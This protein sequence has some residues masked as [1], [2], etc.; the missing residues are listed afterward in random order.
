MTEPGPRPTIPYK[1]LYV[2]A[3]GISHFA[4]AALTEFEFKS[5]TS[6]QQW[7]G[8]KHQGSMTVQFAVLPPGWVADWHENPKP[9]WIIPLS[10]AWYVEAMDGTRHE[11]G[12]GAF[13]FGEDQHCRT[14]DGRT[15]H[16]SGTVG[17]APCVQ[18]IVQYEEAPTI[19]RPGRFR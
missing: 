15:G 2:D 16:L 18:M 5:L 3:D 7:L 19:D 17:D 1:H 6:S 11:F 8:Y 10:G 13:H 9:Q 4:D 14:V 12:P